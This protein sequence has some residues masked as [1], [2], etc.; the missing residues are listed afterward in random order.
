MEIKIWLESFKNNWINHNTDGIMDLFDKNVL[1]YET[2]FLKLSFEELEKEW[3]GIK[4]QKDI[5]L[6]LALFSSTENKHSIIWDL[7]YTDKNH[8][9]N[10]YAGTYLIEL[11]NNGLCTFFHHSCENNH[12]F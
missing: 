6:K 12:K 5:S 1:Y 11:N 10:N 2:P 3:Q 8:K 4:S 9:R 7:K